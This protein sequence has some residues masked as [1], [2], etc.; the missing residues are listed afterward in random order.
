[1]QLYLRVKPSGKE[2]IDSSQEIQQT[3][4]DSHPRKNILIY[5]KD[6]P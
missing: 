1:M 3:P 4:E 6:V 5:K 2:L